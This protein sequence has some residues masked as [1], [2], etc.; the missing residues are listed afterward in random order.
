MLFTKE[1][2]LY[3]PTDV[4]SL[5]FNLLPSKIKEVATFFGAE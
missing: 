3:S 5:V 4:T 2:I 1:V